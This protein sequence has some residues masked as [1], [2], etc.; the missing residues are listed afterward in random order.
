METPKTLEYV[1]FETKYRVDGS[2]VYAFKQLVSGFEG[3]LQFLYLESDDV[4]YVK[5]EEF[6]RHR[7]DNKNLAGRQELTFKKKR[8]DQNNIY[9]IENNVR[10][11]GNTIRGIYEFCTNLGF[12]RNFV[13]AKF[14]HIYRFEDATLPFYTVIDDEGKMSH[15]LEIEVDEEKLHGMT[16]DQAWTVIEKYEKL[17]SP[18]GITPQKRLRKSLFEMY[19]KEVK[20]VETRSSE[21]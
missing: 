6:I 16:E 15:F 18:L 21:Q 5:D 7:F 11:D 17:L 3:L 10:C 13:I 20:D 1:E 14:V 19:R 12:K 8:K 2:L 9:R 4:Y